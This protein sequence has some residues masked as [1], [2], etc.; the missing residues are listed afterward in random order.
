MLPDENVKV[1]EVGGD[2]CE[3]VEI[4]S[5]QDQF[6]ILDIE[7]ELSLTMMCIPPSISGSAKY[8]QEHRISKKDQRKSLIYEIST[9][10]TSITPQYCKE[11]IDW[12]LLQNVI[13]NKVATHVITRIEWG[14]R[15]IID[16]EGWTSKT[17]SEKEIGGMLEASMQMLAFGLNGK[18]ID[19]L[20]D[21]LDP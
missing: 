14:G 7:A 9:I 18:S 15:C 3:Y 20:R 21:N 2:F 13:E 10:D 12:D 5:Q 11:Y 8:M 17:H 6:D 16:V 1:T 19:E 4:N